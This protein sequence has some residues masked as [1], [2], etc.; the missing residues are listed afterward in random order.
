MAIANETGRMPRV[1]WDAF[2]RSFRWAQ[3]EHVVLLGP[4]GRGKSTLAV[5]ILDRRDF[6]VA[7]DVK[8]DDP[9]LIG[10]GY[11]PATSWPQLDLERDAIREG[12]PLRIRLVAPP[13]GSARERI[14]RGRELFG[15]ALEDILT[16]GRWTVYIDELRITSERRLFDLGPEIDSLLIAARGKKGTV[17][18]ATQAPRWIPA[19][20]YDQVR[21]V[22]LWPVRDEEKLR[23]FEDIAGLGKGFR[24]ILKRMP[25]HDVVYVRPPN[26]P[27]ITR[28]PRPDH[29][30]VVVP[31]AEVESAHSDEAPRPRNTGLRKWI[32]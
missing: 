27:L 4:T 9:A 13:G 26:H 5:E 29:A 20:A 30:A 10:A 7:F 32:W 14:Q 22:F 18:S 6:V 28:A 19:A 1:E 25:E 11:E 16:R 31:E 2:L 21:H 8:G 15:D 17:V 3:G 12:K 23:R 24:E